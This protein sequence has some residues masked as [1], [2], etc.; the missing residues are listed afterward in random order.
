MNIIV[1]KMKKVN[2]ILG[3]VHPMYEKRQFLVL[4]VHHEIFDSFLSNIN[5][6]LKQ[7]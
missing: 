4:V 3:V 1:I 6:Y 7:V 5:V 2:M